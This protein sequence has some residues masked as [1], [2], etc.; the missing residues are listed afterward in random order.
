MATTM[1]LMQQHDETVRTLALALLSH[2]YEVRARVEGWFDEP[3]YVYDYR[4]DILARKDDKFII[5]EVKKGDMDW[6]KISA[7]ERFEQ[8]N[9][10]Y[11]VL[12]IE[13]GTL[14][15]SLQL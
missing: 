10:N 2:G 9:R 6:P 11:R 1:S 8:E 14:I 12:I 5:V 4:P 15:R 13:P 3:D 7:L